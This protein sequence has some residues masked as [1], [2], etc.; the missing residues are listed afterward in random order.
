MDKIVPDKLPPHIRAQ[1]EE[2]KRK[3]DHNSA[4]SKEYNNYYDRF[5]TKDQPTY[6]QWLKMK[7]Y[8]KM[9]KGGKVDRRPFE[10]SVQRE[11]RHLRNGTYNAPLSREEQFQEKIRQRLLEE[12]AKKQNNMA[13]GGSAELK[14]YILNSEGTYGARRM[15]RAFDEIPNLENM[16]DEHA[17]KRAFTGD[18]NNTNL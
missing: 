15:E 2:F 16:Y 17:L 18:G 8:Q 14:K 9:A 10:N 4:L 12:Q 3:A 7:G 6:E 1:I 5:Y 11:L 13:K